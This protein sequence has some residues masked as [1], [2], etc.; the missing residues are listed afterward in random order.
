[1]SITLKSWIKYLTSPD[2]NSSKFLNSNKEEK[3]PKSK[4]LLLGNE[5]TLELVK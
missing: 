3:N 1:M 5:Y 4:K 2:R